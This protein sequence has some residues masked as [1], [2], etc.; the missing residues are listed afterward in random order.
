MLMPGQCRTFQKE[1]MGGTECDQLQLRQPADPHTRASFEALRASSGHRRRTVRDLME[2]L[3]DKTLAFNGDS[4]T[5]QVTSAL[6]CSA[7]AHF[8]TV[9]PL[10]K[11]TTAAAP[12][13][14]RRCTQL[15]EKYAAPPQ[16]CETAC[17][18][19]NRSK[20]HL[21]KEGLFP[22]FGACKDLQSSRSP[23]GSPKWAEERIRLRGFVV[24]ETNTTVVFHK[25]TASAHGCHAC[26]Q[27][28]QG[29]CDRIDACDFDTA[30]LPS[31]MSLMPAVGADAVVFN[32]GLHY[33][34]TT[35]EGARYVQPSA[36]TYRAHM[37]RLLQD[38]ARFG[39]QSGKSAVF[40]E[41]SAQHFPV[42]SGD[43]HEAIRQQTH[44]QGP[45][46]PGNL[47]AAAARDPSLV[48]V[49]RNGTRGGGKNDQLREWHGGSFCAA[50]SSSSPPR[51]WRNQVVHDVLEREGLTHAVAIQP[52]ENLTAP[53]WDY[54]KVPVWSNGRW[55]S[56]DCTHFCYS[57]RFWDRSFHDLYHALE[58][59]FMMSPRAPTIE[60]RAEQ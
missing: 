41:T 49:V 56:L 20:A 60:V 53:M 11:T 18:G 29:T 37:T 36:E 35:A 27:G 8:D 19:P 31:H 45:G 25:T 52:F 2:L 57:P 26:V 1:H 39:Q 38:M 30:P 51:S 23:V 55:T 54:H 12:E 13:L 15:R 14:A 10:P 58:R 33:G 43:Y 4:I 9:R 5:E 34:G 47:A 28:P 46:Y 48:V 42:A 3:R 59:G 16:V 21:Y 24:G 50:R 22:R 44:T 6:E 40:R 7:R 32:F 17:L